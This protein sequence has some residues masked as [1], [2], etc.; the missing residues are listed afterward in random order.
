MQKKYVRFLRFVV[1]FGTF[2]VCVVIISLVFD[3]SAELIRWLL[4][5]GDLTFEEWFLENNNLQYMLESWGRFAR[6]GMFVALVS[7]FAAACLQLKD[8]ESQLFAVG[9]GPFLFHWPMGAWSIS[10]R[11]P[12]FDPFY[13]FVG[14][15]TLAIGL[16]FLGLRLMLRW[17][18]QHRRLW[19][20]P[21]KDF[22]TIL[23]E[24]ADRHTDKE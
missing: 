1:A 9:V 19:S 14:F 12:E 15:Y 20:V 18:R 22:Y 10:I 23:H 13:V 24:W 6:N 11:L 3:G 7:A 17:D 4:R 2:M 16:L 8:V 5:R 21:V